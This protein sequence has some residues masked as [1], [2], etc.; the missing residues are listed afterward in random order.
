MTTWALY[1]ASI[2]T[3]LTHHNSIPRALSGVTQ[4]LASQD[5]EDKARADRRDMIGH[6]GVSNREYTPM[7]LRYVRCSLHACV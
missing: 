5:M 3:S 2:G 4:D 7:C 1:P 6:V